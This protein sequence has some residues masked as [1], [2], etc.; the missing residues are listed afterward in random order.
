MAPIAIRVDQ[1]A[2]AHG[3]KPFASAGYM[4]RFTGKGV[5]MLNW[6]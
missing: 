2:P 1:T 5:V 3:Q 4:V 6:T